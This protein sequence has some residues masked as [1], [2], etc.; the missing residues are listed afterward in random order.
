MIHGGTMTTAPQSLPTP[1]V[2]LDHVLES[3][4][5]LN[6]KDLVQGQADGIVQIEYHVAAERSVDCLKMWCSTPRGYSSLICNY[7][8]NPGW[9]SGP[10]FSNGF[11]SRD[12]GRLLESIMLNQNL[13]RI[14]SEPGSNVV[15]QVGPPT[16]EQVDSAKLQ[17]SEI[18]PAPAP[19]LRKVVTKRQPVLPV[20][21][22]V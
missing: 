4:V 17:L 14:G 10:C 1:D 7:S 21:A 18:F 16:A 3:A 13:F 20:A 19:I 11:H 12:L 15:I 2:S 22:T 9:S 8:V 6:W 5:V